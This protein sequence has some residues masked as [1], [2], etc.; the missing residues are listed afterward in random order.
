MEERR[1]K[2]C[3]RIKKLKDFANNKNCKLDKEYSCKKCKYKNSAKW[4]YINK[5]SRKKSII[6][7]TNSEKGI[8][9]RKNYYDTNKKEKLKYQKNYYIDNIE[10]IKL[11]RKKYNKENKSKLRE[12]QRKYY[13]KYPWI[14]MWR[15]IL[16]SSLQRMKK[17]KTE[18]TFRLLGYTSKELKTHLES[19]FNSKMN[20][21][22]Y[23]S[24]WVVDHIKP[25]SKFDKNTNIKEI[26]ALSNLQPLER[27]EN[28]KKSNKYE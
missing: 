7:Y 12:T 3:S 25:V 28:L 18:R 15:A 5:E 11:Y 10:K 1:C 2:K 21:S 9:Y 23:G 6:K 13:K 8:S 19:K 16:N 20:W 17:L 4:N 27:I 24:Y 26:C 22:N 14:K